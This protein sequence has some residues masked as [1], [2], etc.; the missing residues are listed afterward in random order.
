MTK[1]RSI[2]DAFAE[3]PLT[4][5]KLAK[6][7]AALV[8]QFG[9]V[10]VYDALVIAHALVLDDKK[11]TPNETAVVAWMGKILVDDT[12]N[13]KVNTLRTLM[14]LA[15]KPPAS[16]PQVIRGAPPINS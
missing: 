1:V 7:M 8:K 14:K 10:N 15:V 16:D 13:E 3:L 12:I 6:D 4:T 2:D 9:P 11:L 5:K